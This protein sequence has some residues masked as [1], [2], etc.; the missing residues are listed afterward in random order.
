M[1]LWIEV[2]IKIILSQLVTLFPAKLKESYMDQQAYGVL[3]K[4][5][6]CFCYWSVRILSWVY[7]LKDKSED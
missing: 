5:G 7:I 6:E 4:K 3:N 2:D 1:G